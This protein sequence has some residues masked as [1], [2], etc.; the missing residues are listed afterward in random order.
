MPNTNS[1]PPKIVMISVDDLVANP[2]NPNFQSPEQFAEN[3][4]E[5]R[6]LGH[7]HNPITVRPLEKGY[8]IINGE[9]TWRAAKEIGL[10]AVPCEIVEV[11]EF[12]ARLQTLKRNQHGTND[13][14]RL[15]QMYQEMLNLL[16]ERD[17]S[18]R[19][20]SRQIDVPDATLRFY[21]DYAKVADLRSACAPGESAPA[22]NELSHA[23]IQTY[24]KLPDTWRDFWL[25]DGADVELLTDLSPEPI[26]VAAGIA[27]SG[28]EHIVEA[29]RFRGSLLFAWHLAV[30]R[31]EH[32]RVT[33]IDGYIGALAKV[34]FGR[35]Q[36]FPPP[37]TMNLLPCRVR[38]GAVE[39][40]I[41]VEQWAEIID[42]ASTRTSNPKRFHS[43]IEDGLV[44]H[45]RTLQV[46]AGEVYGPQIGAALDEL[47]AA[48]DFIRAADF[49][50]LG[51][52]FQL[53]T[54]QAEAPAD[55]VLR[56]KEMA[57]NHL[58]AEQTSANQGDPK[59][60]RRK[61]TPS[62][63]AVFEDYIQHL[64]Q[65]QQATVEDKLFA[66]PDRVRDSVIA[67]LV[68]STAIRNGQIDGQPATMV[69]SARLKRLESPEFT[70]LA[71]ALL[72]CA[73][74]GRHWAMAIGGCTDVP[75]LTTTPSSEE[76]PCL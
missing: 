3:V 61:A 64:L 9:H 70:L 58:R 53:A 4:A 7:P 69:L 59:A 62:V 23:Q 47:D 52:Q 17:R 25:D 76:S 11:G 68:D 15:G 26:N 30:E 66:D 6:R 31:T 55:I 10:P 21:L 18:I 74:P 73:D 51:E 63:V 14:V 43:L 36:A 19:G 56:A 71:A 39:V 72:R 67:K 16:S 22:I 20:L 65:E 8:Q 5:M 29:E 60:C 34:R 48:P 2:W 42:M 32:H 54:A 40:L 49:L 57:I 12:D 44:K 45:L 24:L 33:D 38:D 75:Q 35:F 13:P 28:L 41:S 37:D 50:T 1:A 27:R 46:S